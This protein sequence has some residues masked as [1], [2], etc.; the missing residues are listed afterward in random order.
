MKDPLRDQLQKEI[1]VFRDEK[2]LEIWIKKRISDV[3]YY[4]VLLVC[5][6]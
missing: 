1:Q 3:K 2:N 6:L 4:M 5:L